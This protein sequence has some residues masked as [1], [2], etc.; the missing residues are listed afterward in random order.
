[1]V[2]WMWAGD[3]TK[4]VEEKSLSLAQSCYRWSQRDRKAW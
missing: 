4:G 1:M 3:G 2:I